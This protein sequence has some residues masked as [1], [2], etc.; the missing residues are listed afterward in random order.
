MIGKRFPQPY[1]K[2]GIFMQGKKG[3]FR[4]KRNV[5][6]AVLIVLFAAAAAIL[7]IRYIPN[8]FVNTGTDDQTSSVTSES[9]GSD[10]EKTSSST[11]SS[12]ETDALLSDVRKK[13][14]STTY[15]SFTYPDADSLN[16][17]LPIS[18]TYFGDPAGKNPAEEKAEFVSLI[19]KILDRLQPVR[20]N[21]KP[22][23]LKNAE[24][25]HISG[26]DYGLMIYKP[27]PGKPT[28]LTM[29]IEHISE[30]PVYYTADHDAYDDIC[31][32]IAPYTFDAAKTLAQ[33]FLK[34][35][36][37]KD[38]KTLKQLSFRDYDKE[39]LKWEVLESGGGKIT[40]LKYQP[41]KLLTNYAVYSVSFNIDGER[42]KPF[43]QGKNERILE[44]GTYY[45]SAILQAVSFVDREKF[46]EPLP[47]ASSQVNELIK[48]YPQPFQS[49][50]E[51]NKR[52]ML[53]YVLFKLERAKLSDS[54]TEPLFT[55]DEIDRSAKQ[56]FGLDSLDGRDTEYYDKDIKL[57][58]NLGFGFP[59][60]NS[61]IYGEAENGGKVLV[62]V[63]YFADGLQTAHK[64]SLRYE[65]SKNSD[66]TFCFVRAEEVEQ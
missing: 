2:G 31:E 30:N 45:D 55:Q 28:Y 24:N 9:T 22:D 8:A 60:I 44:V 46:I 20:A 4:A 27:N 25:I 35:F 5:I 33:K 23:N 63:E 36:E 61:R 65:L 38:V 43:R 6:A 1:R 64:Q 52:I 7:L 21:T 59:P 14:Q 48:F 66:G 39:G 16:P 15:L 29:F 58:R 50:A 32:L 34:A 42:C 12:K 62:T 40:G 26:N 47:A 10:S 56:Y 19:N 17:E 49:A 57:Y 11:S 13:A 51:I 41:I 53:Q 3:F 37:K 18:D 54:E